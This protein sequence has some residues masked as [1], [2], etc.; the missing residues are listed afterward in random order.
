MGWNK[1]GRTKLVFNQIWFDQKWVGPK[2][3]WT[4]FDCTKFGLDQIWLTK[5][6]PTKC[7]STKYG[8]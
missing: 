3:G 8:V 7:I 6:G 5:F 4:K 2:V 1:F